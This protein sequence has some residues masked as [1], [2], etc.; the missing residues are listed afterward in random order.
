[1]VKQPYH[2]VT[3]VIHSRNDTVVDALNIENREFDWVGF[4]YL[5][6]AN[7]LKIFKNREQEYFL[8]LRQKLKK[9]DNESF[10]VIK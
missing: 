6:T 3:I 10:I 9:E 4:N 7:R 1:M 2:L 8:F 5:A